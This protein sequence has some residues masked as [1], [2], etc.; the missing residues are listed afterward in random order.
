MPSPLP[1]FDSLS[2]EWCIMLEI[3][4]EGEPADLFHVVADLVQHDGS[5]QGVVHGLKITQPAQRQALHFTAI[6]LIGR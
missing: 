6:G 1:E 5:M 2:L 3:Y 4:E